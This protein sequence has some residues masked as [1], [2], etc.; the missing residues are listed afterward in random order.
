M[1]KILILALCYNLQVIVGKEGLCSEEGSSKKCCPDYKWNGVECTRCFGH[2]GP[3]CTMPCKTGFCGFGCRDHCLCDQCDPFNCSC[4]NATETSM[5]N[6]FTESMIVTTVVVIGFC[7]IT[8]TMLAGYLLRCLKRR[9]KKKDKDHHQESNAL[10]PEISLRDF[11]GATDNQS[12]TN[13]QR[14][15]L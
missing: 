9:G 7:L 11:E 15:D 8:T 2:F 14:T 4:L 13:K 5:E 1:T 6:H 12:Q 3:Q 10:E